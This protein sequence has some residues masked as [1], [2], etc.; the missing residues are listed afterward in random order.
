MLGDQGSCA[1]EAAD[2]HLSPPPACPA[3]FSERTEGGRTLGFVSFFLDGSQN[4]SMTHSIMA[5]TQ[6]LGACPDTEIPNKTPTLAAYLPP[7]VVPAVA[8]VV[9][10]PMH[11]AY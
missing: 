6:R 4:P 10:K 7:S 9:Q 1:R 5:N 3:V 11:L 8:Q 2:H